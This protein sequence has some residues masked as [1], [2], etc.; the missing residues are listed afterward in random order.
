MARKQIS[1]KQLLLDLFIASAPRIDEHR[2]AFTIRFS[3]IE[4]IRIKKKGSACYSEA[5]RTVKYILKDKSGISPAQDV[6]LTL[7]RN[8]KAFKHLGVD[9]YGVH[10]HGWIRTKKSFSADDL[11]DRINNRSG[12]KKLVNL[13]ASSSRN[14]NPL[15]NYDYEDLYR[16]EDD[17]IPIAQSQNQ[18]VFDPTLHPV[19]SGWIAYMAKEFDEN[20]KWRRKAR[21]KFAA[22]KHTK[23]IATKIRR[24]R[25]KQMEAMVRWMFEHTLENWR[26]LRRMR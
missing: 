17:Y 20:P 9:F 18:F 24:S 6:V 7:E 1:D 23:G 10:A 11:D 12:G 13:R 8:R 3:A 22:T 14:H 21:H 5:L 19:D 26:D 16:Y 4:S 15:W 2:L 25:S